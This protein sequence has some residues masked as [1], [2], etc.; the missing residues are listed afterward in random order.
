MTIHL[1]LNKD[2]LKS[3]LIIIGDIHGCYDELMEL[4]KK[5]HHNS[6]TDSLIL[7]GDLVCKGPKSAEVVKFVS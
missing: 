5:C 2:N 6:K 7:V 1:S 4:L 3:R